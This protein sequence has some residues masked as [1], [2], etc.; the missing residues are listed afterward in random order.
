MSSPTR[1]RGGGRGG[2]RGGAAARQAEKEREELEKQEKQRELE[3]Q[4][5]EE[6]E[7]LKREAEGARNTDEGGSSQKSSDS[8]DEKNFDKPIEVREYVSKFAEETRKEIDIQKVECRPLRK[9]RYEKK[10]REFGLV[11]KYN[12]SDATDHYTEIKQ[13]PDPLY[14]APKKIIDIG[15]QGCNP[16][17]FGSSQTP[18]F[19]KVNRAD[20]VS[21]P[22]NRN[23]VEDDNVELIV[24]LQ[25][26]YPTMEKAL[27]SNETIDIFQD[28]FNVLPEEDM[29]ME[30][31]DM[32]N[33]IKEYKSFSNLQCE[34]KK[35]TCIQFQP[36]VNNPRGKFIVA[37]S[38]I[39]NLSFDDRAVL[40]I[41]SYKSMIMF[42]DFEDIHSIEPILILNSPLE[43]LCFDFNPKDPNI[44]VAGAINGQV[45]MWNLGGA[46]SSTSLSQKKVQ[47]AKQERSKPHLSIVFN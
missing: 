10:R 23:D 14:H 46:T 41:K 1:P 25:T 22:E 15:L 17:I 45:L 32:T 4:Q 3:R 28:D 40:A 5:K 13:I 7:R 24:F 16:L 29:T 43:I 39:E 37:E 18:W 34:G 11:K 30:S 20:Q 19:R 44:V 27:Q 35:I 42:W 8:D 21:F 6:A 33:Q 38:F 31:T 12:D 36:S 2:G 9:L 26:V 47:K